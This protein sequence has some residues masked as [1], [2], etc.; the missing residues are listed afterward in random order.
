MWYGFVVSPVPANSMRN[1]SGY[2]TFKAWAINTPSVS[3]GVCTAHW[4]PLV[5][6]P[7]EALIPPRVGRHC[8]TLELFVDVDVDVGDGA[9]VVTDDGPGPPAGTPVADGRDSVLVALIS[10]RDLGR[11]LERCG[12]HRTPTTMTTTTKLA[13]TNPP[14]QWINLLC[15]AGC[16][17][18]G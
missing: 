11:H 15:V 1:L 13:N 14:I 4:S 6:L 7:I 5:R 3:T 9:A 18:R 16:G 17:C 2:V 10:F 8:N 12:E